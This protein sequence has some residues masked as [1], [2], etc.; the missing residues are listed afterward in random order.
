MLPYSPAPCAQSLPWY[1]IKVRTRSEPVA[2]AVLRNKGY[3]P[4]S[5]TI[6]ER[7]RYSDRMTTVR[8]PAFP[9]YIFCRLDVRKKVTVLSC[10]AIDY[11]VGFAGAL[12]IVPDEEIDA[13]RCAPRS[14]RPP[15]TISRRR[16]EDSD[17]IRLSR[18][19]RSH[20][21]T[22]GYDVA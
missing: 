11:I 7:R 22:L 3:D 10:P 14:R 17:R 12:A 15:A 9:G 16:S 13:V 18:R 6:A 4:F 8:T 19:S 5:P 21:R 2:V 1:A 20:P